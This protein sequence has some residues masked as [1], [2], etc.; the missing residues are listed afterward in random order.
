[1][2][3]AAALATSRL[4]GKDCRR[5]ESL[6]G[7]TTFRVGGRADVF[8]APRTVEGLIG[9]IELCRRLRLRHVVVGGGSNVLFSDR[10]FRGV[11]ISTTAIR[12]ILARPHGFEACAGEPLGGLVDR[13]EEQGV[14]SLSF[15][16]GIPGTVGGAVAMNAGIR[17]RSIGD[18]VRSVRVLTPDGRVREVTSRECR[19]EY[20]DSGIRQD[21]LIV[22]AA[23]LGVDG[24]SYD[25]DGIIERKRATQPL[26]FPSAG[27]V[28]RNPAG[29]SAGELIDRSGMKG[30]VIGKAQVSEKHANFIVNLGGA[31]SAEICKLIDIVRQKVYKTFHVGLD[32]EIEVIDG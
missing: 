32:L 17:D 30:V 12:G 14:R 1:M 25:R 13:A 7:H 9:A 28:F 11:V 19:F 26:S 15:L 21:G 16:A 4:W 29:L 20:R 2:S 6:A 3:N 22:L 24:P 10:G 23:T 8:H 31:T 5:G 27:C 18:M